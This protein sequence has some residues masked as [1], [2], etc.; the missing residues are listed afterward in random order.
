[1]YAALVVAGVVELLDA[2]IIVASRARLMVENCP[3]S[4]TG[5]LAINTGPAQVEELL[6]AEDE[7]SDLAIACYNSPTD[8]VV[9][10]PATALQALK[11]Q[12]KNNLKCKSTLLNNPLA[13]HTKAMDP[14]VES[15]NE[16]T[17][18]VVLSPP[19]IPVVSNGTSGGK[20]RRCFYH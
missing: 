5:M 15:L 2:L 6:H 19:K 4:T 16:L 17:R 18:R 8:C 10:G 13:Y 12:L 11:T 20:R 1:M 3:F 14:V 9:G 7:Y